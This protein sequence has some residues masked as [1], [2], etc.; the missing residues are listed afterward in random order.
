MSGFYSPARL[1]H[2]LKLMQDPSKWVVPRFCL[3][4]WTNTRMEFADLTCKDGIYHFY[5][6]A[7]KEELS[8]GPEVP[9][10]LISQGW[11]AD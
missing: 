1:Q 9:E 11:V 3:K 10:H 2:D 5:S 6:E 8:G 4:R 7:G